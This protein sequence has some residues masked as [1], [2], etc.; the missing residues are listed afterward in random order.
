M[1]SSA[2]AMVGESVEVKAHYRD[3]E[4]FRLFRVAGSGDDFNTRIGFEILKNQLADLASG[5]ENEDS[6]GLVRHVNVSEMKG[7]YVSLSRVQ[8]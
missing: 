4:V 3:A 2:G 8:A 5:S 1:P 7:W 6:W